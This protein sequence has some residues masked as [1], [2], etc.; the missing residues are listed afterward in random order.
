VDEPS[1]DLLLHTAGRTTRAE[2]I[3]EIRTPE[4]TPSVNRRSAVHVLR[5]TPR[6]AEAASAVVD[7]QPGRTSSWTT[8]ICTAPVGV[9][10]RSALAARIFFDHYATRMA[11]GTDLDADGWFGTDVPAAAQPPAPAERAP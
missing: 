6:I 7:P 11:D 1:A 10:S 3:E 8:C 5:V 2:T 4:Y 9:H